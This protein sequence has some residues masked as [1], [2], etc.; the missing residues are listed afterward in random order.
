M[1]SGTYIRQFLNAWLVVFFRQISNEIADLRQRV[2]QWIQVH[3]SM[4]AD[5]KAS[6]RFEAFFFGVED[7]DN[8]DT[9]SLNATVKYRSVP[10][11]WWERTPKRLKTCWNA[12]YIWNMREDR[13]TTNVLS[14]VSVG[15]TTRPNGGA[16]RLKQDTLSPEQ[17][18]FF[19]R[20]IE[21]RQRNDSVPERCNKNE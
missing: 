10:L 16:A 12:P 15:P 4:N 18:T 19:L 17:I 9:V 14:P 6:I 8:N 11:R 5:S 20:M 3:S 13:M 2:W 21:D 1:V 7:R